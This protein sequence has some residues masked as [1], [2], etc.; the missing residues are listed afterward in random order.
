[1]TE[2]QKAFEILPNGKT[3]PVGYQKIPCHMVFDIKMEDFKRKAQL[4]A[5]DHKTKAPATIT[6]A[7]VV[8]HKTVCIALLLAALNDLQIKA[9]D[10]LNAYITTPVKEKVWTILGP[11]FGNDAGKKCHHCARFVWTEESR[12]SISFSPCLRYAPNGVHIL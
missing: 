12:C 3:A 5:G 6:Y 11:K 8:S 10:V 4:A 1:M 7:S 9:G 2:V